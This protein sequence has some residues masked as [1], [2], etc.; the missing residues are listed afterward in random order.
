VSG[1]LPSLDKAGQAT[2]DAVENH[3]EHP[4]SVAQAHDDGGQARGA[5]SAPRR[6]SS[7]CVTTAVFS[8]RMES[9][10]ASIILSSLPSGEKLR[11]IR[12]LR[13]RTG[14][15]LHLAFGHRDVAG[16]RDLHQLGFC[17][18]LRIDPGQTILDIDPASIGGDKLAQL[19]NQ[20]GAD[21]LGLLNG[22][23][24]EHLLGAA[25]I[26]VVQC[27]QCRLSILCV[28]A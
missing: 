6:I 14:Q 11:H 25:Q 27:V 20:I 26:I 7:A 1:D 24:A 5:C 13:H 12:G 18:D 8:A 22:L 9:N 16:E 3:M 28:Y 15:R 19:L 23:G 10:S 4:G 21:F 17:L 2:A